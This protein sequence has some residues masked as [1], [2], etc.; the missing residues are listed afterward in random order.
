M[1]RGL[2]VLGACALVT[3]VSA[4]ASDP[5]VKDQA[6]LQLDGIDL[7]TV[8]GQQRLAIRMDRAARDV[9]GD[10][11]ESIHLSAA[12]AARECRTAVREDIRQQ[13]ETRLASKSAGT[14]LAS[15]R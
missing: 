14:Q 8:D 5:F 9:C 6:V 10:G 12:A 3:S 15:A 11:M 1:N 7:S 2:L 4:A 13:I